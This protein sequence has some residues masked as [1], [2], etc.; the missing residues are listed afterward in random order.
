[1]LGFQIVT[2]SAE[3]LVGAEFWFCC[4]FSIRVYSLRVIIILQSLHVVEGCS[5][6]DFD[7]DDPDDGHDDGEHD[8]DDES[9]VV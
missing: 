9:D 5:E 7:D 1:M 3:T 2:A 4:S 8:D 6:A